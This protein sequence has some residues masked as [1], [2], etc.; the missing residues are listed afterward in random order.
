MYQQD[1]TEYH[2]EWYGDNPSYQEPAP[3]DQDF[4]TPKKRTI[5]RP[6]LAKPNFIVSMLVCSV[7]LAALV[8]VLAGLALA[9]MVFGIAKG[10]METAPTLDLTMLSDQD[11]TSFLYD[12]Q[13]NVITDYK[14]TE[15]RIM[16]N[17]SM[18][19]KDLCNAFVA[20]EDARFYTHNG[21]DIKRIVGSFITNFTTGSQQ[22]GSTI[23]QQL[24]KNTVLSSEQSYKRKIQEAYLAM[25]LETRYTKAQILECYLNTIYLGENYYGVEVAAQGYFGKSL[26]ELTLRECAMLAGMTN[27]PYYYNP[28]RNFYT[29]TSETTDYKK[30]TNDRT[31]YVLRCMYE[32]QFI[33]QAQ[34]Q[35]ALNPATANI[36][37]K[38]SMEGEGMYQHAHYVEYAVSDIIDC[39]LEMRDLEN[40]SENRYKMENELRTGGYHVTLAIDTEIQQIVEDTL[41]NWSSY[42]SLRDPSDKVYRARNADGTYQEIIQPQVAAVVMDYRTGEIKAIVGSRT[43]PTQRKTL[44][45]ATDMKMPIGSSIK[46]IAVYAP[47]LELGASPASIVYNMPLPISGWRG[48]DGKDSWPRNYGGSDYVG[49]QTFRQAMKRSHNVSAA[50]ALIN[51]VGVERSV[52]F[53]LRMGVDKDHIDATPFGLSLGS[54]GITPLQETVAYSVLANGGIYQKPISFLGISDSDGKVIYDSHAQQLR[55]QVFRPSTSWMIV[56]MMKDVVSGG[57]ATKAKISGQTVAGKTG[58][59]SD[60]RG[61]T[62]CGMT[63]WYVSTVWIGH[64]NYKPLSSKTTGGNSAAPLWQ[65]YMSKIHKAKGLENRDIIEA[66]P[67]QLELTRVTTC[68]VSGQLATD[69]CRNDAMGYGVVTDYW[70]APTAPTVYCQMHQSLQ[71]CAET[72]MIPSDRCR[73]VVEK[74]VVVIPNGHP[75]SAFVNDPE[76]G[77]VLSEY[78]GTTS[79]YTVCSYHQYAD[80][81]YSNYDPTVQNVLIPDAQ[82]LIDSAY[83]MMA[84]MDPSS[85][86]YNNI[87][88]AINNLN[89]IISNPAASTADVAAAMAALT[90]AMAGY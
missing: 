17:I 41:A 3:D 13:G 20:V 47:A 57:T 70:Y 49:P 25:Q 21:I 82:Q 24:I 77:S 1:Q 35:E 74:G 51:Y 62:F 5:F 88:R 2:Q 8:I 7:R 27:N 15:N 81:G 26:N 43:P 56:D 61:V 54:S 12:A 37:E 66:D 40:T 22:G 64:D 76:Y 33:T 10:Y 89:A 53:L 45:R 36:L 18:M 72:N 32:N 85:D 83:S 34:Y 19:P 86:L 28:R 65:S 90:Q 14:G 48:S 42:P 31:D 9:G 39:F 60:S 38:S 79:S 4:Y 52:D 11:K 55:F 63:G 71:L 23:T 67:A 16:V 68:A 75:L 58:T 69:A 6:R 50:Q 30:I 78:L 46:P 59:N 84:V 87:Q 80:N 73:N 29:R 44:N